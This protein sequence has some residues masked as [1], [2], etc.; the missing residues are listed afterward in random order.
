MTGS[1]RNWFEG[2]LLVLILGWAIFSWT[3]GM[4]GETISAIFTPIGK[5]IWFAGLIIGSVI[6]LIG[7]GLGTYTGLLIERAG[8]FTLAGFFGWIGLAFL[9][10]FFRI[11]ALHLLFVTPLIIMIGLVALSRAHQIKNDLLRIRNS[12]VFRAPEQGSA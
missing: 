10:F 6:S 5:H 4:E 9:G 1:G 8:M 7:F 2:Y 11:N 3:G 12:I